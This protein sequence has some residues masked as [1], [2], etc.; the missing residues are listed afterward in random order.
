MIIWGSFRIY[1]LYEKTGRNNIA[2]HAIVNTRAQ[3]YLKLHVA[4]PKPIDCFIYDKCMLL[5]K[6]ICFTYA[7]FTLF[8]PIINITLLVVHRQQWKNSSE[9]LVNIHCLVYK[10][11]TQK[12]TNPAN[13][14]ST[15]LVVS[16]IL[17]QDPI[18]TN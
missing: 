6:Y 15:Q 9:Q 5:Y 7:S 10:R 12:C 8:Y 17:T 1:R 4:R 14:F 11:H 16:F 2:L 3:A 18:S 13:G